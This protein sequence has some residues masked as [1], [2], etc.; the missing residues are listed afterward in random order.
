VER[1]LRPPEKDKPISSRDAEL[2]LTEHLKR[3]HMK[4]IREKFGINQVKKG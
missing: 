3:D 4:K 1:H 2:I